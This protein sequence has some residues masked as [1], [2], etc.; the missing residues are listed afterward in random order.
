MNVV[1]RQITDLVTKMYAEKGK[2]V[3]KHHN[4]I[5]VSDMSDG[6]IIASLNKCIRDKWRVAYIPVFLDEL[7][8][9]GFDKTHP[10]LFV[11]DYYE[12]R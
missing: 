10:E 6:H 5:L 8:S 11:Q 4:G 7:R 1:D 12:I 3:T 2:W 9:R